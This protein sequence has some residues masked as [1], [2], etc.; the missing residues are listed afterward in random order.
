[1]VYSFFVSYIESDVIS[2][3]ACMHP[4]MC[5]DVEGAEKG[6]YVFMVALGVAIP[7]IDSSLET[8]TPAPTPGFKLKLLLLLLLLL[9]VLS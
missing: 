1:M 2:T 9:L 6:I 7:S 3:D 5:I 8:P 4:Q